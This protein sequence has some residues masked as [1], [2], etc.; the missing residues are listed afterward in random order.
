MSIEKVAALLQD[1]PVHDLMRKHAQSGTIAR[2]VGSALPGAA[3]GAIMGGAPYLSGEDASGKNALKRMAL[4]GGLGALVGGG[5]RATLGNS[6]DRWGKQQGLSRK[7]I[8]GLDREH[9]RFSDALETASTR[10]LMG[11][12]GTRREI[13]K[14]EKALGR[15]PLNT[16]GRKKS[17][18][19][20][21]SLAAGLTGA[22]VPIIGAIE[23]S[24]RHILPGFEPDIGPG[25]RYISPHK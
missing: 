13:L 15:E 25:A 2:V 14:L 20:L 17:V 24:R 7:A 18:D 21:K 4:L 9:G 19:D 8:R 10:H 23:G 1:T 22:T 3:A 6:L 12:S 5:A 16:V 11:G